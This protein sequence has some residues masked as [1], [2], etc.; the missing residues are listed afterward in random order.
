MQAGD[1]VNGYR[2]LEDFKVVGAGL[3]RWTFAERAGRG[4]FLKEFLSPTYPD[5]AAPGSEKTKAKKR[6]RCSAFEAHHRGVQKALAPLSAYGGNLIVTL[7]FFRWGAKYYKVTETVDAEAMKPSD[8]ARLDFRLQL[9]LLKSV[10]HSL[11]I[12][13]DLRIVHGDLKPSNILVKR[14]ALGY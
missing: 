9:V 4:F 2:L 8:I 11:K 6:A 7:D 10:A 3:S 12:L 1:V 5:D 14:T 13:H